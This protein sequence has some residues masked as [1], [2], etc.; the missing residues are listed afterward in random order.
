MTDLTYNAFSV[1][2][3]GYLHIRA[4][5]DTHENAVNIARSD[6]NS[7]EFGYERAIERD[8]T[9]YRVGSYGNEFR[10]SWVEPSNETVPSSYSNV[11]FFKHLFSDEKIQQL[12]A[13]GARLSENR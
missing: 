8:G 13:L 1:S 6:A 12:L 10:V 5:N 7:A 3:Y 2:P 4:F 11:R 9:W